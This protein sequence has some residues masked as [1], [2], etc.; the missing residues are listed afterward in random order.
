MHTTKN[1]SALHY[2]FHSTPIGLAVIA[3]SQQKV[4]FVY[5]G[6]DEAPLLELLH[7]A[8]LDSHL[9][10]LE[11]RESLPYRE[12]I[13]HLIDPTEEVVRIG[14]DPRGSPFQQSVWR[15]LLTIPRGA[16]RSYA[17]VA[18]GIGNIKA[19]RAVAN[20]C[21]QNPIALAIPCH[22]VVRKGGAI[23]GYRWGIDKKR[24]LLDRE[25]S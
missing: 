3:T 25:R 13:D 5:I 12:W 16:V 23:G 9:S 22:R 18:S 4:R 1:S 8:C 20:A 11:E 15:Y 17:D 19:T 6:K 24:W 14:I 10:P 21:G 7:N 2:L